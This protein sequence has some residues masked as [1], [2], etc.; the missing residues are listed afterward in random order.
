M[1]VQD[2]LIHIEFVKVGVKK[3]GNYRFKLHT[4]PSFKSVFVYYIPVFDKNKEEKR[5]IVF[6]C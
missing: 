3:R 5:K 4:F 6:S 2:Y 1:A